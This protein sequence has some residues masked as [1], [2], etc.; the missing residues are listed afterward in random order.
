VARALNYFINEGVMNETAV[1]QKFIDEWSEGEN[2]YCTYSSDKYDITPTAELKIL[3][4][5]WKF[6]NLKC[7]D[8]IFKSWIMSLYY[9][10]NN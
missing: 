10:S 5:R 1:I 7:T 3:S 6:F 4:Q 9:E 8:E 2:A